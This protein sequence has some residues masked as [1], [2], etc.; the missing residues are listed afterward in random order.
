MG[1]FPF[2]NAGSRRLQAEKTTHRSFQLARDSEMP[3]GMRV[4]ESKP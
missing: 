1:A 3:S 4:L 2:F